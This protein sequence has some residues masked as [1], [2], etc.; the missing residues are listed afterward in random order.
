MAK[1]LR[2]L[3]EAG[4]CFL[5]P[6]LGGDGLFFLKG[7]ALIDQTHCNFMIK[8]IARFLGLNPSAFSCHSLRYGGVCMLASSGVPKYLIEYHGGWAKDSSALSEVYLHVT[9]VPDDHEVGH[10]LSTWENNCD[11]AGVRLRHSNSSV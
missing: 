8:S 9:N 6:S 5:S 2:A 7:S 11:L 4:A 10:V 3:R 1:W